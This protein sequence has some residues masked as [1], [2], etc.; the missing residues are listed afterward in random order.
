MSKCTHQ[1]SRHH[2]LVESEHSEWHRKHATWTCS[3]VHTREAHSGVIPM[4]TSDS[5]DRA[6][7][8]RS[9]NAPVIHKFCY[10]VNMFW[11]CIIHVYVQW[12]LMHNAGG[13]KCL[14]WKRICWDI[15]VLIQVRGG[16]RVL[17]TSLHQRKFF[18]Q[19]LRFTD[20]Y[21][22]SLRCVAH[23]IYNITDYK[24]Y[25]NDGTKNLPH[26]FPNSRRNVLL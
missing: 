8:Q 24:A 9:E 26:L 20:T 21:G 12:K 2:H 11:K 5:T 7:S 3:E 13:Q 6:T 10:Q 25:T 17:M 22:I 19:G 4:P 15:R 23:F 1:L 14:F 18:L 16:C